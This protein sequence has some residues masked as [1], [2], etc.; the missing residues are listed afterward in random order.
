[1]YKVSASIVLFNTEKS[2][3]EESISSF[4]R[5]DVSGDLWLID[6]SEKN[7]Y[8][9]LE[10]RDNRIKYIPASKNLGYGKA[11]NLALKHFALISDFHIVINPDVSFG[12]SVISELIEYIGKNKNT[13]LIS[14]QA[15]YP[16]GEIQNNGRLI[17]SP[18]QLII[19]RLPFY[20]KLN[21]DEKYLLKPNGIEPYLAPVILGSFMLF[22]LKLIKNTIFFDERFFLYPEDIDISRRVFEKYDNVIYPKLRFIHHHSQESY[23]SI[24]VFYIHAKEMIKYFN[25]WGW[26]RDRIRVELNN[27]TL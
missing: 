20:N 19:R 2:I 15:I 14:P 13:G 8:S 7:I 3:V 25:K 27:K 22:N 10:D 23:K 12:E 4:L 9:Y 18:L 17:P 24:S 5:S 6:N 16:N 1:M 11:H 26:I 21:L